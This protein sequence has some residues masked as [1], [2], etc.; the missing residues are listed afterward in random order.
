MSTP[1]RALWENVPTNP[2]PEQDLGYGTEPLTVIN[3]PEWDGQVIFLPR[4]ECQ[5]AEDEFLVADAETV[6]SLDEWV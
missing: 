1:T 5:L 3:T 4:E 2:D 6:A